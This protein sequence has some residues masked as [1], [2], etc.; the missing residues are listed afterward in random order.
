[1]LTNRRKCVKYINCQQNR[2]SGNNFENPCAE[3]LE[4]ELKKNW[5][6]KILENRPDLLS[7][8]VQRKNDM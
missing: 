8:E 3:L 4:D 2:C 6:T 7:F 1:M 5:A